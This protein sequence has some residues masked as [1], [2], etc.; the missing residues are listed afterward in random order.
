MYTRF[1]P[2]MFLAWFSFSG[3][4]SSMLSAQTGPKVGVVLSGGGAKGYAHIGALKVMEEAGIRVDYIG[5]T[6]M[7]SI[8]GGLYAAGWPAYALDSILREINVSEMVQ[9]QLPRDT[10][11]FLEKEYGEH[12]SFT[13]SLPDFQLQA[14]D[15]LSAGQLFYD[16]L[17][18]LT[19]PVHA[20]RNFNELPI[21]F[22]CIAT[23]LES[24]EPVILREGFLP[25]AMRT[26]GSLPIL[27]A[28]MRRDG[29]LLVDGGVVNNFPAQEVRD[30]GADILIGITVEGDPY[31]GAELEHLDKM[32][33]QIAFFQIYKMSESQYPLCDVLIQPNIEGYS[34]TSFDDSDTLLLRGESAARALWDTL[35]HIARLQQG[36]DPQPIIRPLP[37]IPDSVYI[38]SVKIEDPVCFTPEFI[39]SRFKTPLPGKIAYDD[40]FEGIRSLKG[41][42]HIKFVQYRFDGPG[43]EKDLW[44]QPQA[45]NGYDKK[46]KV[47]IHY[48]DVYRASFLLNA[49]VE[50]A[51]VNNGFA[52]LDLI[53]LDR[54]RYFFHY[55]IDN[56][57]EPSPGFTSRLHFNTFDFRLPE[58]VQ[59]DSALVLDHIDVNYTDFSNRFYLRLLSGNNRTAGLGVEL[60]YFRARSDQLTGA[61][62]NQ[63]F[64]L[65][66]AMY[67]T[68]DVFGKWDRL[69]DRWFPNRG[70]RWEISGKATFPLSPL[71]QEGASMSWGLMAD[72]NWESAIALEPRWTL[73]LEMHGGWTW[74]EVPA[75]YLF[76]LG[77][78]NKN[79]INHFKPFPGLPFAAEGGSRLV[80]GQLNL[81]FNPWGKHYFSLGGA[82]AFLDDFLHDN[83]DEFRAFY[84][85]FFRYSFSSPLGPIELTQAFSNAHSGIFYFNLGY[86]F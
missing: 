83:P 17:S 18:R 55:L 40:F 52:S 85:G 53:L 39:L 25:D 46:L 56:G 6:S 74:G 42:G 21:P 73:C 8:V 23:D 36:A 50:H 82:A 4:F 41:T 2:L 15:A 48:D 51:L 76:F 37:K 59:L 80:S 33:A 64:I 79:L 43:P 81:R 35:V 61:Q 29:K 9:D 71:K 32:L 49:T 78:Y 14:P 20:I 31:S 7:G 60:K 5:G 63:A 47:G 68:G 72:V 3:L 75:P 44:M 12:Y 27:L 77:G 86:W 1:L 38:R 67:L 30:M 58:P 45:Q 66:N 69:D 57:R 54:F 19:I 70:S 26:S 16:I 65:E 84:S 28:P 11:S 10:R 34:V 22:L 13:L 62:A 24:G